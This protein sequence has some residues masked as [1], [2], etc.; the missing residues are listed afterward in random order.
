MSKSSFAVALIALMAVAL[1]GCI[2]IETSHTSASSES[3]NAFAPA[4]R[5]HS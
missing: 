3:G 4:M 5:S 2:V 1:S